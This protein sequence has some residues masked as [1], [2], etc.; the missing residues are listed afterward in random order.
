MFFFLNKKCFTFGLWLHV[1][2]IAVAG[3]HSERSLHV[4]TALSGVPHRSDSHMLSFLGSM[5]QMRAMLHNRI[6]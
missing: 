5:K 2:L 6:T 3:K 1:I 4:V